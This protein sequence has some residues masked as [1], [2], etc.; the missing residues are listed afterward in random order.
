MRGH[1]EDWH[2]PSNIQKE[3]P[4][5]AVSMILGEKNRGTTELSTTIIADS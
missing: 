5:A 1:E 3:K 4:A 2:T